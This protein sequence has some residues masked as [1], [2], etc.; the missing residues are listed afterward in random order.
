MNFESSCSKDVD[1]T[2]GFPHLTRQRHVTDRSASLGDC[3]E[4][5]VSEIGIRFR[6]SIM[7]H[8][9]PSKWMRSCGWWFENDPQVRRSRRRSPGS[10][11]LV[12]DPQRQAATPPQPGFIGRPVRHL[13]F[14]L[15]NMMAPGVIVFVRHIGR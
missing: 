2:D 12:A 11:R 7:P 8:S 13:E 15:W 14:H 6:L 5:A 9:K 10:D 1:E 4:Q 3:S